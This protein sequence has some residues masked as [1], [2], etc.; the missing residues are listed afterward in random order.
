MSKL[1]AVLGSFVGGSLGWWLGAHIGTMT[2][3]MLSIVGTGLGI[4]LGHR[5]AT[6]LL[7]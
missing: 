1:L 4:Y 5:L 2:A 6:R 3:Y 7:E